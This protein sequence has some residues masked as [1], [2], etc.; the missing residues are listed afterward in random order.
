VTIFVLAAKIYPFQDTTIEDLQYSL[1]ETEIDFSHF[2]SQ[3]F[4]DFL[5]K[6]LSKDPKTRATVTDLITDEW[7]TENGSDPL[8]LFEP[9]ETA[10]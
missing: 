2:S 9:G 5:K 3:P 6:M 7:L 4:I 1:L 8:V 10:T